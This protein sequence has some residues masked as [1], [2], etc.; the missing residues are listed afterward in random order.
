MNFKHILSALPTLFLL[1]CGGSESVESP[2]PQLTYEVS[3]SATTGG[4]I[5]PDNLVVNKG[6]SSTLTLS[7]A[8]GY[9]LFDVTGCP[10]TLSENTYTIGPLDNNCSVLAS[11][12]LI[13][14]T[15]AIS[16]SVS[17]WGT[18]YPSN[19]T[20]NEGESTSFTI[21][22][23]EGYQLV[24][25][26]GCSGILTDDNYAVNE[27]KEACTIS[28]IFS[29]IHISQPEH[30][31]KAAVIFPAKNSLLIAENK[32][33]TFL[34][35]AQDDSGI[36]A[37]RVNGIEAELTPI[38]SNVDKDLT[39]HSAKNNSTASSKESPVYYPQEVSWKV[40]LPS[41]SA[42]TI[43]IETEDTEGNINSKANHISL[44]YDDYK[45]PYRFIVDSFHHRII[46]KA[47]Q[48]SFN[49]FNLLT[50]E[51]SVIPIHNSDLYSPFAY[52]AKEDVLIDI[53]RTDKTFTLQ[54]IDLKS[55]Q[56]NIV[57]TL[58]LTLD[59]ELW[60][61][62]NVEKIEI[63]QEEGTA[64][65]LFD[66][67]SIADRSTDKSVI[68]K[69]DFNNKELINFIDDKTTNSKKVEITSLSY[70]TKGF[71]VLS[72]TRGQE[73]FTVAKLELD[74]SD[75]TPIDSII[76]PYSY[77]ITTDL[78]NDFAY[79]SD[80]NNI[81]RLNLANNT[82][83]MLFPD[84]KSTELR[85]PDGG[86]IG[87]DNNN[88]QL[89]FSGYPQG[90]I[91]VN[92]DSGERSVLVK[93]GIGK[94]PAF[95]AP[96][97]IELDKEAN[98]LFVVDDIGPPASAIYKVNLTTGDRVKVVD[99]PQQY[100]TSVH[101][102]AYDKE[103]NKLF[104]AFD[105]EIQSID[106]IDKSVSV[107]SSN[108]VSTG[109]AIKYPTGVELDTANNRLLTFDRIHNAIIA[110]NLETGHRT[111]VSS[112]LANAEVGEGIEIAQ[113]SSIALDPENQLI[114]ASSQ[115]NAHVIRV[116]LKTGNRSLLFDSCG[117]VKEDGMWSTS[118]HAETKEILVNNMGL[119]SYNIETGECKRVTYRFSALLDLAPLSKD[120]VYYSDFNKIHLLNLNSGESVIVSK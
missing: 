87:V 29:L 32:E 46:G 51:K 108:L 27:V 26:T 37:V 77:D 21:S 30:A 101:G 109:V 107:L 70:S 100:N 14:V 3:T 41:V 106:L 84:T 35:T 76:G 92:M 38:E 88:N 19:A 11:F 18:I 85:G 54:T 31:P 36:R 66:Y 47:E 68:L 8:E 39:K 55:G 25:V 17:E 73:G 15:H 71:I 74:G 82:S 42:S 10:G 104:I 5:S 40:T 50:K 116:D 86:Y 9:Q 49:S 59:F 114:Y 48:N 117:M 58:D 79:L 2:T 90:I 89:L 115:Y 93:D 13:P 91:S 80:K 72:G 45:M 22:A 103:N 4:T 20:V 119:R 97:A 53:Y 67:I 61:I 23:N 98:E 63:I 69:Y 96:R 16:T 34:G 78:E 6:E 7:A 12:T 52:Y 43:Y 33:M 24:N 81:I 110:I 62:I 99:L 94:G 57:A 95:S 60:E 83:K 65:L 102:M 28:A 112:S 64:Y 44:Q 111:I 120:T 113:I 105:E 118:Y 75:I 1:G 56:T